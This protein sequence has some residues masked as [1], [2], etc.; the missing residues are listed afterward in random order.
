MIF[1]VAWGSPVRDIYIYIYQYQIQISLQLAV[2]MASL[3][4]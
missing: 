3:S 2:I 4:L 1:L